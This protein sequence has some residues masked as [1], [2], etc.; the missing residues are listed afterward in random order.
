MN[1]D[2]CILKFTDHFGWFIYE[3]RGDISFVKLHSINKANSCFGGFPLFNSDHAILANLLKCL[4]E[5]V[6][7][8]LI[9][10]G[11]N[12]SY[13]SHFFRTAH[14]AGDLHEMI[15]CSRNALLNPSTHRCWVTSGNNIPNSFTKDRSC[16][17]SCGCCSVTSQI[18]SLG[19]HFIHKLGTH[20]FKG[21]FKIDFLTDGYP[22]LCDGWA[23]KAFVNNHITTGWSHS[24]CDSISEFFN[25]L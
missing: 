5:Q 12:S 13:L 22:I 14:L 1:Q 25:T 24:D 21:I 16:Q 7:N 18:R 9:V 4:S 11:T 17:D 2:E 19:G 20:V 8:K 10:I 15:H 3:V 6:T 23:T